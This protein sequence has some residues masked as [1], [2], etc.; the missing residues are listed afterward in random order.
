MNVWVFAVFLIP[1]MIVEN[2]SGIFG[3]TL[4]SVGLTGNTDAPEK[5]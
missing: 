1:V 3:R 2:L 4:T 5:T